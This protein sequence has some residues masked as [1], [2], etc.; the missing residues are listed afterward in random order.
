MISKYKNHPYVILAL[1]SEIRNKQLG[2]RPTLINISD[3]EFDRI[4]DIIIPINSFQMS[5]LL[6]NGPIHGH[7]DM[8]LRSLSINQL[9]NLLTYVTNNSQWIDNN[10]ESILDVLFY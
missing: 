1:K 3:E 6:R 10:F 4:R 7:D 2:Y 9:Y 8:I 5:E